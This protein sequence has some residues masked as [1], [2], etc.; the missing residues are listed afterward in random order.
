MAR[1]FGTRTP[2]SLE[3]ARRK[4]AEN[5]S[6][7]MSR[8][9]ALDILELEEGAPEKA[10]IDAYDRLIAKARSGTGQGEARANQIERAKTI[11]LD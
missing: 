3:D 9:E 5:A 2:A 7:I 8:V 1:R 4:R 10:I 6:D 11:L